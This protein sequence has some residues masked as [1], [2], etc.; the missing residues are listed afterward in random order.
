MK[1]MKIIIK[2]EGLTV[3]TRDLNMAYGILDEIKRNGIMDHSFI[4]NSLLERASEVIDT[5]TERLSALGIIKKVKDNFRMPEFAPANKEDDS[6]RQ[7]STKQLPESKRKTFKMKMKNDWTVDEDKFLADRIDQKTS[8]VASNSM[9][10]KRHTKQAIKTRH[11]MIKNRKFE[12]M[13]SDR[14]KMM[15]AYMSGERVETVIADIDRPQVKASPSKTGK[16]R[17]WTEAEKQLLKD[18]EHLS[19]KEIVSLFPD[20]TKAG[21]VYKRRTLRG[22]NRPE[23]TGA[24]RVLWT[25]DE[26]EALK[27]NFHMKPRE[28]AK[29]PWLKD[30]TLKQIANKKYTMEH[31]QKHES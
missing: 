25:D 31:N 5:A 17:L 27:L 8:K 30:K 16:L 28:L 21:I 1:K 6:S 26:N 11:S 12:R 18:N 9:L 14:G 20:R 2:C 13:Q 7:L 15:K 3:R 29:L 10:L 4:P 22:Y 24:S 23:A 19:D